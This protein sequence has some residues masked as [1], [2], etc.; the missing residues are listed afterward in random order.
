MFRLRYM[1]RMHLVAVEP[2]ESDEAESPED[3]DDRRVPL[4]K[5]RQPDRGSETEGDHQTGPGKGGDLPDHE[6]PLRRSAPASEPAEDSP[7]VHRVCETNH[8]S[9]RW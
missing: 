9:P 1:G 3:V 4:E 2:G 8:S 6:R 7:R 5:T